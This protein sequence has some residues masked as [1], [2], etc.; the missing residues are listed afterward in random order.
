MILLDTAASPPSA[1]MLTSYS[2]PGRTCAW[3]NRAGLLMLAPTTEPLNAPTDDGLPQLADCAL[4]TRAVLNLRRRPNDG[5]AMRLIPAN[6]TLSARAR[7]GNWFQVDYGE[8]TG[9]ISA[10]YVDTAGTCR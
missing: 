5:D 8:K 4:S 7:E 10:R 2:M 6:T 9:W 3:I 1:T